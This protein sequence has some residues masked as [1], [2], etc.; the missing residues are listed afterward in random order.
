[1]KISKHQADPEGLIH[2]EHC[3]RLLTMGIQNNLPTIWAVTDPIM[4]HGTS[5]TYVVKSDDASVNVADC[6]SYI[7]SFINDT[8]VWHM[9]ADQVPA[10]P[11]DEGRLLRS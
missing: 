11:P 1:M 6:K 2:I 10:P 5:L 8:G 4:Q 9:F 3:I 7:T